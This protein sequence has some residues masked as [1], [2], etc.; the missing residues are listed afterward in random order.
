MKSKGK[1]LIVDDESINLEFFDVMLSKLGF[2]VEKASDGE[3]ALEKIRSANPDL[4]L[5]DNIMPK[6]S[7]WDVTRTLKH[8]RA[9]RKW[10][11]TPII[12]FTAMTDVQDRID[13]LEMGVDDYITK[14]FN[15]S[16]V[17]ARI[18]AVLRSRELMRQLVRRE[19]RIGVVESLNNSLVYFSRH[20][21]GPIKELLELAEN[22]A[23]KDA[24]AAG[25][26]RERVKREGRGILATL[27]GL[28]EE[29]E[30]MQGK[31]ERLRRG[32]LSLRDLE[33]RLRRHLRTWR[34]EK[35]RA[36][37]EKR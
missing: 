4:V 2:T 8:D 37:E 25:E 30:E 6:V 9:W 27:D 12:M 16:E 7:G 19:K 23:S 5:L 1:I 35:S 29:V 31:G 3:E 14:P 34:R 21:R 20:I 11:E 32:D 15:F 24:K 18:R 22:T 33:D 13:G 26:L 17:V 28:E 36:E 10:R